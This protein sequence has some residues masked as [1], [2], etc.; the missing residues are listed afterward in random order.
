MGDEDSDEQELDEELVRLRAIVASL[1]RPESAVPAQ[2]R[3]LSGRRPGASPIPGVPRRSLEMVRSLL[4]LEEDRPRAV[5]PIPSHPY[6]DHADRFDR[7]WEG[8]WAALGVDIHQPGDPRSAYV[9]LLKPHFAEAWRRAEDACGP[10]TPGQR[11]VLELVRDGHTNRQIA[12]ELGLSEA[13]VR[14]HL[15][16]AYASLDVNNRVAAVAAAFGA[17]EDLGP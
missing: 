8:Y 9:D 3:N 14:T 6:G 16:N 4:D 2:G 1:R 5:V 11:R 15:Q 17:P 10:L 12:R 13:T 7:L